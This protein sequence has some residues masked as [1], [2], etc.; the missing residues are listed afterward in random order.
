MLLLLLGAFIGLQSGSSQQVST[1]LERMLQSHIPDNIALTHNLGAGDDTLFQ[2]KTLPLEITTSYTK[3]SAPGTPMDHL[4]HG[5]KCTQDIFAFIPEF[6][7][8]SAHDSSL[9]FVLC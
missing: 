3:I 7:I 1:L 8:C 6:A 5:T 9:L 4:S 2:P